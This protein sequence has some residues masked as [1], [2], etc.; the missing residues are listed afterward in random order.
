MIIT[1]FKS[2]LELGIMIISHY[3]LIISFQVLS[4]NCEKRLL[5][6]SCLSVR[7]EQLSSHWT[8][9][10]EIR[11]LSIFLKIC[12]EKSVHV[13]LKLDKNI[14]YLTR[15]RISIYDNIQLNSFCNEKCCRK[16]DRK[17][18]KTH[19]LYS[20]FFP[21]KLPFLRLCGKILQNRTGHR[22]RYNTVH[23][24]WWADKTTY[25]HSEYVILIAFPWLQWV[26]ERA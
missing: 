7:M 4:Q 13:S 12:R 18:I 10:H 6:S 1:L 23:M 22:W 26:R 25:T 3:Y 17:K 9:F 11:Y 21:K 24:Q 20:I 14:G 19:I 15:R 8:D 5:A 16:I 2:L